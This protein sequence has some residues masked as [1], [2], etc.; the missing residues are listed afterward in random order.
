MTPLSLKS[1]MPLMVRLT[2]WLKTKEDREDG[3]EGPYC[4]DCAKEMN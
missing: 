1:V 3:S 2:G 4:D